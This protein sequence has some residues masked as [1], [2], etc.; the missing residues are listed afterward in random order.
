[1]R[2]ERAQQIRKKAFERALEDGKWD[3]L[4]AH[5]SEIADDAELKARIAAKANEQGMH[6]WVCENLEGYADGD[7]VE[8]AIAEGK[9][10]WLGDNAWQLEDALQQR[11][12]RA[13]ADAENWQW[14]LDHAV[15]LKLDD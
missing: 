3:W 4:A 14:L 13:A 6:A 15:Q 5:I 11:V 8:S 12:A 7:I 1:M 2:S 10:D 9:W